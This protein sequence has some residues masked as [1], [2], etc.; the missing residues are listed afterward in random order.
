M[1]Q[2]YLIVLFSAFPDLGRERRAQPVG[3]GH[4]VAKQGL[5]VV[6]EVFRDVV[7]FGV[8]EV[9]GHQLGAAR[10]FGKVPD[11]IVNGI[12]ACAVHGDG[13]VDVVP[14]GKLRGFFTDLA[15]LKLVNLADAAKEAALYVA[16]RI[17]AHAADAQMLFDQG[18]QALTQGGAAGEL[19]VA[20][21]V[22]LGFDKA[23]EDRYALVI[24]YAFAD[25]DDA[26]AQTVIHLLDVF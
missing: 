9:V 1:W 23:G 16:Q 11:L 3:C 8:D 17:A 5:E 25:G 7:A 24:L 20:V 4:V 2:F 10:Y 15:G 6:F 12:V 21:R 22:P 19:D 18:G 14:D 13:A 26:A